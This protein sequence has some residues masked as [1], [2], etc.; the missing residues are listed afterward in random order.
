M[1]T[2]Q[3]VTRDCD[4]CGEFVI[5]TKTS[6][7]WWGAEASPRWCQSAACLIAS[8]VIFLSNQGGQGRARA[9]GKEGFILEEFIVSHRKSGSFV[10]ELWVWSCLQ[11]PV[12]WSQQILLKFYFFNLSWKICCDRT[13]NRNLEASAKRQGSVSF[14]LLR[15]ADSRHLTV[16][17]IWTWSQ[18]LCAPGQG[19]SSPSSYFLSCSKL[20]VNIP[21]QLRNGYMVEYWRMC[22]HRY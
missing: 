18:P 13:V 5:E 10:L 14:I 21:I 22:S 16:T 3:I 1:Y 12:I 8:S 11:V 9:R 20:K 6:A 4:Y 2:G 19:L 7:C 17:K 15:V